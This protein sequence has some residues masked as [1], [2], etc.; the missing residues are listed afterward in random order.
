M[1]N[2]NHFPVSVK[3][4]IPAPLPTP[5]GHFWISWMIHV[6]KCELLHFH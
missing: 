4:Q 2:G 5:D 6:V 3:R 1:Y